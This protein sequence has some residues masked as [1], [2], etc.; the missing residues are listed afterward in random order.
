MSLNAGLPS[1]SMP[2]TKL[3]ISPPWMITRG[4]RRQSDVIFYRVGTDEF[5]RNKWI[6]EPWGEINIF[7][8]YPMYRMALEASVAPF[9]KAFITGFE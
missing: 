2:Y 3:I 5:G 9:G 4:G 6:I 8:K 7:E 1:V